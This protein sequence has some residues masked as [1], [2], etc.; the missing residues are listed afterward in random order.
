MRDATEQEGISNLLYTHMLKTNRLPPINA[1]RK[2][3]RQ[4]H[5]FRHNGHHFTFV[6][7][8][9]PF[10]VMTAFNAYTYNLSIKSRAFTTEEHLL[11]NEQAPSQ[12]NP[13]HTHTRHPQNE[14]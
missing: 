5:A 14:P 10:H 9:N 3:Y 8:H 11:V 12:E 1:T 4:H 7:C 2:S 6:H 13:P